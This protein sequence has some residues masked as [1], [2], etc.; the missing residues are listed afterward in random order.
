[1]LSKSLNWFRCPKFAEEVWMDL[2]WGFLVCTQLLHSRF[3][4][5]SHQTPS[6]GHRKPYVVS[7]LLLS[8]SL[9]KYYPLV[10]IL[11]SVSFLS[12]MGEY[13]AGNSQKWRMKIHLFPL[14]LSI[15]VS[16]SKTTSTEAPSRQQLLSWMRGA[17]APTSGL[18]QNWGRKK[19][20]VYSSVAARKK[21]E[22]T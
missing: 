13:N 6:Q 1:M 10:A 19:A 17:E 18:A 16:A 8:Y 12:V 4:V 7:F 14:S 21:S 3:D 5:S 2:K 20:S 9:L 22:Q 15:I 11:R